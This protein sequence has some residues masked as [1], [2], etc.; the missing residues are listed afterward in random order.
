M[1]PSFAIGSEGEINQISEEAF[2]EVLEEAF[3]EGNEEFLNLVEM[4]APKGKFKKFYELVKGI[5]NKADSSAYPYDTLQ[6][7]IVEDTGNVW[8]IP[9]VKFILDFEIEF[10]REALRLYKE[11][12]DITE[13]TYLN[14][15]L[16]IITNSLNIL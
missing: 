10:L 5:A 4:Y 9:F 13:G 16:D 12:K 8:E 3:K 15:H 7:F 6:G 1:D 11:V 14:K 2:D